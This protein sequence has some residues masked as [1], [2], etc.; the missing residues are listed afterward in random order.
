AFQQN[1]A[2]LIDEVCSLCHKARTHPMQCL[3]VQLLLALQID[4]THRRSRCSFGNTL[5]I[6]IIIFLGFDIRANIFRRHQPD[7]VTASRK[8][9]AQMMSSAA[10]FH[11]T[12]AAGEFSDVFTQCLA[13]RRSTSDLCAGS[14]DTS[15]ATRVLAQSSSKDHYA[16]GAVPFFLRTTAS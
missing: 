2:K 7:L 3:D 16:H 13:P 8:Q 4:E 14:V 9:A 5:S 1:C 12:Y 15:D 11:S 6:P 10:C